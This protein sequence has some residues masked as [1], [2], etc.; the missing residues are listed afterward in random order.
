MGFLPKEFRRISTKLLI[1]EFNSSEFYGTQRING[2]L[3]KSKVLQRKAVKFLRFAHPRRPS[4]CLVARWP[5][6]SAV[7][8]LGRCVAGWLGGLVSVA[9]G[10]WFYVI[11]PA[12]FAWPAS[13]GSREDRNI[14][15]CGLWVVLA[16]RLD[17]WIVWWLHGWARGLMF[18]LQFSLNIIKNHQIMLFVLTFT[19][20]S[21]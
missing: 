7:F 20:S 16:W 5:D 13:G 10:E 9:F 12:R 4:P 14:G 17:G 3:V 1:N 6:G 18:I 21:I 11:S 8:W 19:C 15:L 2:I